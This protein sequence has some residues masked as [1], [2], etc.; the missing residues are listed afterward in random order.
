MTAPLPLMDIDSTCMNGIRHTSDNIPI[1]RYINTSA[2]ISD[3]FLFIILY[4]P[5]P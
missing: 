4:R 2:K 1:N 3:T 5:L